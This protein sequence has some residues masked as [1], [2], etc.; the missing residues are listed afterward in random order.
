MKNN[1]STNTENTT[2]PIFRPRYER[3]RTYSPEIEAAFERQWG[4]DIEENYDT[5]LEIFERIGTAKDCHSKITEYIERAI[6][7]DDDELFFQEVQEAAKII[8]GLLEF[9]YFVFYGAASWRGIPHEI[10][11][12]EDNT[13]EY[14]IDRNFNILGN[15]GN[16]EFF[17]KPYRKLLSYIMCHEISKQITKDEIYDMLSINRQVTEV[18]NSL[19]K[20]ALPLIKELEVDYPEVTNSETLTKEA[21]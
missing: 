21:A 6:C 9:F 10:D 3:I 1:N 7:P 4:N 15:M 2:N 19:E 13:P 5:V 20:N 17:F 12:L 16:D 8:G 14:W 18:L 11:G